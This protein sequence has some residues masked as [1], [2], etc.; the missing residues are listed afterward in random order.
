MRDIL[1]H[2]IVRNVGLPDFRG[3]QRFGRFGSTT[4]TGPHDRWGSF[5]GSIDVT[6][7]EGWGVQEEVRLTLF[8]GHAFSMESP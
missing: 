4:D 6:Y 8:V 2:W 3:H 5:L 7:I 1:P